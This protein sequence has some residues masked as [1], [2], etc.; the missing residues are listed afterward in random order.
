MSALVTI[1]IGN[2]NIIVTWPACTLGES[3]RSG[4]TNRRLARLSMDPMVIRMLRRT[5]CSRNTNDII[6]AS[7]ARRLLP[8]STPRSTAFGCQRN[9]TLDRHAMLH[10]SVNLVVHMLQTV[11]E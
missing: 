5:V 1:R 2:T 7:R 8:R 3:M 9:L 6:L 4:T 11:P 10:L